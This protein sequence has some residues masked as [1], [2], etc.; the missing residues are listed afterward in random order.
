MTSTIKNAIFIPL[1]TKSVRLPKK[2]LLE[3]KEKTVIEH[4]IDR[5]KTAKLPEVKYSQP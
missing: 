2:A 1:R 3:I 5:V 4:L